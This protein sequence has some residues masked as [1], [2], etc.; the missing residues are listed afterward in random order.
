[1]KHPSFLLVEQKVNKALK[2]FP[3][4]TIIQI[5]LKILLIEVININKTL[6]M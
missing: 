1:M 5:L 4:S 6:H 2:E 3:L